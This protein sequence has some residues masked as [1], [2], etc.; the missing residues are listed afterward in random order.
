MDKSKQFIISIGRE[1]G[2]GGH[3]I[4]EKIAK[5]FNVTLYDS[6]LLD[7][8]A[9]EK[10]VEPQDLKA[11][12]E[13]PKVH[14]FSRKV[15]GQSSSLQEN[16]A[17]MQFDYLRARAAEGKSFVVVGRCAEEIL[18]DYKCLISIF[19][20]GDK[21]AKIER[22]SKIHKLNSEDAWDKI[23]RENIRRKQYHNYYCKG[24]WGDSRNYDLSIN[25]SIL[26]IDAT[27]D[28]LESYIQSRIDNM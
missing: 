5:K 14:F 17:N 8:I 26:G 24:K 6:N 16:V 9:S 18:K 1:Y 13:I 22:I 3:L 28:I 19:I 4:A 7:I 15:N 11:Y 2:S 25:D 27:T 23:E 20:L 12:D 10:N 21:E